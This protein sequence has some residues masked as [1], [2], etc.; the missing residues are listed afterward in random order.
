MNRVIRLLL[1]GFFAVAVVLG[2]QLQHGSFGIPDAS[3]QPVEEPLLNLELM[4]NSVSMAWS[5]D[6][7]QL[8]FDAVFDYSYA[9]YQSRLVNAETG[10]IE[11]VMSPSGLQYDLCNQRVGSTYVY[12]R[13]LAGLW[14]L[15]DGMEAIQ[16]DD[17][18]S[19]LY[20]GSYPV[21]P[22]LSP[23]GSRVLYLAKTGTGITFRLYEIP[24]PEEAAQLD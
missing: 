18:P 7:T 3:A 10:E 8:F 15:F 24:T 22:C 16:L 17:T 9:E 1:G 14:V 20:M 11:E 6:G 2:F 5:H 12:T 23:D 13:G 4:G 21:G 19:W